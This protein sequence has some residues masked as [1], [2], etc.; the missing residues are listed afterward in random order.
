[1]IAVFFSYFALMSIAAAVMT[2]ALKNP[3]HCGLALLA[4]RPRLPA[5]LIAR[6]VQPLVQRLPF[7]VEDVLQL[8][9]EDA[10]G[11]P[12]FLLDALAGVLVPVLGDVEGGQDG[13]QQQHHRHEQGQDLAGRPAHERCGKAEL[14]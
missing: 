7:E 13:G 10:H 14:P 6:L 8:A 4:L 11:F 2:V 12:A 1:M 3:V 5:L 9:H